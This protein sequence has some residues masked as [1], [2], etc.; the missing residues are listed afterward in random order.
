MI[1]GLIKR[2]EKLDEWLDKEGV[3]KEQAHLNKDSKERLYWH[4]GY[5]MALK[6]V[7]ALLGKKII[8]HHKQDRYN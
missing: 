2:A 5:L 4:Y 3:K 8:I 7:L 6:D 1:D